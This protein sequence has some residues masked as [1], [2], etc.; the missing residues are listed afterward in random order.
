[1]LGPSPAWWA[2]YVICASLALYVHLFAAL[3][4]T[5]NTAAGAWLWR[6]HAAGRRGFLVATLLLVAPYLPLAVWQASVLLQGADVGYRPVGLRTIVVA[7]L[8]QLTW[9]LNPPPDR[10]WLL[11]LI[12]VLA[13][14]LWRSRVRTG[15]QTGTQTGRWARTD[16]RGA[17]P[18]LVAVPAVLALWLVVPVAITLLIQGSVPVFRDRYFIPLLAPLLILLA[19]AIAPPWRAGNPVGLAAALFVAGGFGY[20]LL[21]RPPNP[22]FRAAAELVRQT[23]AAGE[24]VGFL[25]EYAERPFDFYFRQG[26]GRYEKVRLPYTNYPGMAERD[27]L[28]A[29]ARSLRGGRWLWIIRFEDWLWDG[30]DL[31]SQYLANRGARAVLHR[32]FNGVSVT[33]YE[34][35]Q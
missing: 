30:R 1:G 10:R 7:L 24:P 19:R 2:G 33:R 21:H 13:W 32:D 3:Q 35:P 20:G 6:R 17:P 29:V 34:M 31:A 14:G 15:P 26:A 12:A 22:D 4:I 5:A 28:L 25:A 8:E 16:G 11:P 9:H 27:G 23:A 18:S